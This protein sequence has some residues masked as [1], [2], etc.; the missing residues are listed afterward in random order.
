ALKALLAQLQQQ[1]DD[2]A[3]MNAATNAALEQRIAELEAEIKEL[4]NPRVDVALTQFVDP[5]IGTG[6]GQLSDVPNGGGNMGGFAFPAAGRPF[7]MVN[8]GADTQ[9]PPGSP[10]WVPTGYHYDQNK[11]TGFT[12][13]HLSGVGCRTATA[14]PFLPMTARSE[15]TARYDHKD[16]VA[17]PGYY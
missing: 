15:T 8:W 12:L 13:T 14:F 11:I 1:S 10:E 17:E 16:E 3:R 5:F 2:T 9:L 6:P 4:K 7:G